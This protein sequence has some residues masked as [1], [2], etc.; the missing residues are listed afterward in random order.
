MNLDGGMCAVQFAAWQVCI[1]PLCIT[2][3]WVDDAHAADRHE[4]RSVCD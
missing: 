4:R 1:R 2:A 3:A